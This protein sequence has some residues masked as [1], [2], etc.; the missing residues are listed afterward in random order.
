MTSSQLRPPEMR[1][2][3]F[4]SGATSICVVSVRRGAWREYIRLT[5]TDCRLASVAVTIERRRL[6]R[7]ESCTPVT[8][9]NA[10]AIA[11]AVRPIS[12]QFDFS[13]GFVIGLVE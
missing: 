10:A 13:R 2:F 6:G 4:T 5:T 1:A 12:I 3:N 8:T 9:H 11:T 7:P